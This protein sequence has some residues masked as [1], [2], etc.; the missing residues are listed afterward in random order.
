V[1]WHSWGAA[2]ACVRRWWAAVTVIVV[3]EFGP[4]LAW[5]IIG[6]REGGGL[7]LTC[8]GVAKCATAVVLNNIALSEYRLNRIFEWELT[9]S[10]A[11]RA[12]LN[13][14]QVGGVLVGDGW[15]VYMPSRSVT[16]NISLAW[17]ANE[18]V[19]MGR[20]GHLL[21]MP[22]CVTDRI[23]KGGG[24]KAAFELVW[25]YRAVW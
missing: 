3:F 1:K 8:V 17:M 13:N 21:C 5:L 23:S 25:E 19:C 14:I 16:W 20:R 24:K 4:Q 9:T 11:S 15:I 18:R 2:R 7:A 10:D 22:I 12:A 6:I